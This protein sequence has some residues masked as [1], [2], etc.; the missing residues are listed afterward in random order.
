MIFITIL[1]FIEA[2]EGLSRLYRNC[3]IN[4][5]VNHQN[6]SEADMLNILQ[7]HL[8]SHIVQLPQE[9]VSGAYNN[10]YC[11][12]QFFTQVSILACN[13]KYLYY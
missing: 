10:S 7:R 5:S 4:D 1:L 9:A 12:P 11:D 3:I 13:S 6:L 8:F 2:S